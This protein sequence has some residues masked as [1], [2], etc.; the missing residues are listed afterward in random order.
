MQGEMSLIF[1]NSML[2]RVLKS[3]KKNAL[4]FLDHMFYKGWKL[5]A[6]H[7]YKDLTSDRIDINIAENL[8]TADR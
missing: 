7:F 5:R 6:E 4:E 8:L 1:Q 2:H 3:C